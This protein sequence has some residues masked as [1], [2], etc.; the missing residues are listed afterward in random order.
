MLKIIIKI[1][2]SILLF[3]CLLSM[4]YGYYQ[5]VRFVSMIVFVVL[6]YYALEEKREVEAIIFFALAV[7]FQPLFKIALGRTIW[8]VVDVM[9][10]VGL[11]VSI[12]LSDLKLYEKKTIKN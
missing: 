11:I 12:V 10:G 5:F 1:I 6:G 7:L 2:L 4:P 8:N 9:I 3:L